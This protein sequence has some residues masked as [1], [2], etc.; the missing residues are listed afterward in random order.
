MHRI[1]LGA[2]ALNQ[3]PLDWDGNRDRIA[4]ACAEARRRK[5]SVLCCPELCISGYGCEDAFQSA[6]VLELAATVLLELEPASRGLL[7]A[8]GLPVRWESGIYDATAVL[9]DGRLA[10][11]VAK[12]HLAGEGLHYEPRWFRR[13]PAGRRGVVAIADRRVPI[14][15]LRF[16]CGGVRI[17]FE[18]CEDAWT[19]DRPGG[20][21]AARGVDVILNPS[22]S[23]FAFGKEDIRRRF[24]LEGA[25]AY[26]AAYV[27]A[28][29][30]GNEAGRVVY[31]GGTLVAAPAGLVACGRRFGFGDMTVTDGLVDL[32]TIRLAQAR[33]LPD[34]GTAGNDD[35]V[36][37]D[38]TP[39]RVS[40]DAPV[41][42]GDQ[43]DPWERQ[44]AT[45]AA[46][47]E[48][49]FTR[50]VALGLIDSLRKSHSRGFVVS[51]SGGADSSAVICLAAI[52]I[53]LVVDEYGPAAAARLGLEDEPS[54]AASAE[55]ADCFSR[56]FLRQLVARLVTCVYQA[57]A[58][59]GLVTRQ[60]AEALAGAVGATFHVFEV[61]SLV[62]GY[63]RLVE[64][65]IGRSLDWSRDDLALQN[66]QA[67]A[68]AP[69]VWMLANLLGALLVSTSN[70]SEAA[71]GYA[72]MDGDTA[73]GIAPIAGIDKAF[74]R[75]WLV[76]LE[77][78]GPAGI[79][80]I[81]AL[82]SVTVQ[83][84]TA[85]LRPPGAG[86]TDEADLMPYE[87]LDRIERYAIR[88]RQMPLEIWQQLR[89]DYPR[90]P[91]TQLADWTERFFRLWARNQW[92][93]ERYAPSFHLDD[94]SLDPKS[95]CRF[96]ILS[97]GFARELRQLRA[98]VEATGGAG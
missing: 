53:A 32:D 82:G 80:A 23:H 20:R 61:E 93:R 27:Y 71:V 63:E 59:S 25:R 21:L 35:C 24:V 28:N 19:A 72:T 98:A 26:A 89:L 47:K 16:S 33:F 85:E 70:R 39:P 41:P 42:P 58:H 83:Q 78:R 51:A 65:A 92:K 68:R 52:G 57:T 77:R 1:R 10:G 8:V 64:A 45:A 97:G 66:I 30:L 46:A 69:G 60:A 43:R 15:D 76:W 22:A 6:G 12:Q 88:D 29:L 90:Q 50:A 48:E 5:V 34:A 13:W 67:R 40:L 11:L 14:G 4:A 54:G 36:S 84:P 55:Q 2:A 86:Q 91:P 81:P 73:G 74:L 79:G 96:P 95:W 31:D 38:F 94:E 3:T 18:I 75:Q 87:V 17:G 37:L 9:V 44:M 49:E 62:Q 7:L 56:P